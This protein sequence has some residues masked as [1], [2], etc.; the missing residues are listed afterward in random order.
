MAV[1]PPFAHTQAHKLLLSLCS[2]MSMCA[3]RCTHL[4]PPDTDE[5]L[6]APLSQLAPG[7]DAA[8]ALIRAIQ[9]PV[10][11]VPEAVSFMAATM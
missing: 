3:Q 7:S 6:G 5:M 1:R 4:H 11:L 8:S 10:A 9:E 2:L